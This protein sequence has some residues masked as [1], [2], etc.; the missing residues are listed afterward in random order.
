M[1]NVLLA[2]AALFGAA[3]SALA[4]SDAPFN[5]VAP[6]VAP[7]A[8]ATGAD[9]SGFYLGAT[10]GI[11]VGGDTEYTGGSTITYPSLE[12]GQSYGG[13]AGY[14]I[15]RNNLVFGGEIAYSQ[16]ATPG[17]GPV[18]YPSE[19]L[20]YFLDGKAR[21]GYALNNV[22]VYGFAGYSGSEFTDSSETWALSGMN[23]GAGVDMMFGGSLFVGAEYIVRDLSGATDNVGQTQ[24]TN[25]QEVQLRAGWKF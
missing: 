1:K 13:F 14:N 22:L 5:P 7:V 24:S 8:A 11:G 2:T 6:V 15:Q 20:N 10:Y 9:W 16:V 21:V 19:T 4:G 18:G 25:V 3:T 17:F 23:Y 12:P